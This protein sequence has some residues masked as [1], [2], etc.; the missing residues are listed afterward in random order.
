M[1]NIT[2]QFPFD[3][4]FIIEIEFE[5]TDQS[6]GG[7]RTTNCFVVDGYVA[8]MVKFKAVVHFNKKTGKLVEFKKIIDIFNGDWL[9]QN[10]LEIIETYE[11]GELTLRGLHYQL[12]GRGMINHL[13]LYKRACSVIADARRKGLIPYETFSDY[14]RE[15]IGSTSYEETD[16]DESIELAKE[17]IESWMTLY[18]KHR[19]ENQPVYLEVFIEKKA[20][21]GMFN[22]KCRRNR[23]ALGACKGYPSLTFLND[24]AKR[25]IKAEEEGKELVIL[26]F[27]DYDP[28]G[29]D[30]PR[31]IQD[32]LSNDFGV[33]VNVD[34]IALM[35]DQVIEWKLPP[36]PIKSGDSRSGNWDG[37]GQVELDAVPRETINELLQGSLDKYF[38]YDLKAKLDDQE[39]EE[40]KKYQSEL[41]DFINNL[42]DDN[43]E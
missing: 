25:F 36:A 16:V 1:E 23:V 6:I 9:I 4:K 2:I 13:R 8:G 38:D 26:Y 43:D 39:I 30:I 7:T 34:R 22:K 11:P 10:S 15:M 40:R 28:S 12:V 20:L 33:D 17:E 3:P 18:Y 24:T 29:E 42:K 27:G 41:K 14:E 5:I 32:N 31:S 37:I 21:I 35:H 19:W